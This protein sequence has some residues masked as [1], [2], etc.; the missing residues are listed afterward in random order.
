MFLILQFS[1]N[2]YYVKLC[3]LKLPSLIL[4]LLVY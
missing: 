2:L 4:K 1:Y 3:L